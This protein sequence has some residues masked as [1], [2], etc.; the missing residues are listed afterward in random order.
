[1]NREMFT[2]PMFKRLMGCLA[3]SL[4]LALM[5]GPQEGTQEDYGYALLSLIHI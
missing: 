4:V 3:G 2:S 5:I 1:M